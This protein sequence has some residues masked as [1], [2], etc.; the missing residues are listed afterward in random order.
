MKQAFLRKV[1]GAS[2]L[3]LFFAGWGAEPCMFEYGE[4]TDGSGTGDVMMCW[5][6]R[7]LRFNAGMLEGYSTT[8]VLAW[9]MGVWAAG[10]VLSGLDMAPGYRVA[11]N[12][13]PF[14]IHDSMGIPEAVFD[15]TLASLSERDL[16][17]F[18]RRMCGSAEA[19]ER[20]TD[21]PLS[22]TLEELRE[23]LAALGQAVRESTSGNFAWSHA[24]IGTE[25]M[26]FPAANQKTAWTRAGV[27]VSIL[28]IPHWH[29]ETFRKLIFSGS[30]WTNN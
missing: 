23:E 21:L 25:D 2:D 29:P 24:V 15:G 16:S 28:D 8:R 22:R 12:G 17:K 3:L 26:I 10:R 14:P 4:M 27:P 13:T 9:S 1:D 7:D 6:Y 11:V 30:S 20:L 19:F 18:R 5:D